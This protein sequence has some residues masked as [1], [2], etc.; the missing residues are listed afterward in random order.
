MSMANIYRSQI[1]RYQNDIA[2]LQKDSA[3]EG[4]TIADLSG[5]INRA[6]QALS[7]TSSTSTANSR[8][9]EIERH[10]SA[11]SRA[12]TKRA[13]IESKIASKSADLNRAKGNLAREEERENKKAQREAEKRQREQTRTFENIG[14]GL[15]DHDRRIS[16]TAQAVHQLQQP[17][18][19]ITVLFLASNPQDQHALQL[20]EEIRAIDEKIRL[21]EHRD[22]VELVSKWAVRPADVLQG[23]NQ[24][25]PQVVHISG[26]GAESGELV[27]QDEKGKAKLISLDA[28]VQLMT[29]SS[30]SIR[31]IFFNSCH[32]HLQAEAVVEHVEAA[33]G[34]NMG[35]GDE[36]ARVFASQFYSA[37][38]FGMSVK[39]A[40]EQ[41]K[42]LLMLE[43]IKEE[44]TPELFVAEGLDPN[45]IVLVTPQGTKG[46]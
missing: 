26:H 37:I 29:A 36:A 33:I 43:G 11:I 20:D 13:G 7:R 2:K 27:F 25:S 6:Q 12:E 34:M 42:A 1:T 15:Q 8:S 44:E 38:G 31:F 21:S 3:K 10:N 23:L 46:E 22:S 39:E 5:K 9:R 45:D 32:S 28:M 19:K 17:V 30:G 24:H 35:I 4:K 41:A 16:E 40:F 14:R 18:E